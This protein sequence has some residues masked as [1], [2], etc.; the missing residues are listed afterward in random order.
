MIR[1]G[2]FTRVEAVIL[3]VFASL[4]VVAGGAG[5]FLSAGHGHW[6]L[7]LASLGILVSP[8][9]MGSP[10]VVAG[11]FERPSPNPAMERTETPRKPRGGVPLILAVKW[12]RETLNTFQMPVI[13]Q[14]RLLFMRAC[15]RNP[16]ADSNWAELNRPGFSSECLFHA[17]KNSATEPGRFDRSVAKHVSN[18]SLPIYLGFVRC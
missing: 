9:F 2:K 3:W 1:R 11:H 12:N 8:P 15:D 4:L 7:A 16:L 18:K 17:M 13:R 10:V 14:L 6:R 5:L